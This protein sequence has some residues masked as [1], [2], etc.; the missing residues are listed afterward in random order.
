MHGRLMGR[1]GSVGLEGSGLYILIR[2]KGFT[3]TMIRELECIGYK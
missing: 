3:K 2:A 1:I